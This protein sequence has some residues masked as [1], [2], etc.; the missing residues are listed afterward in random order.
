MNIRSSST[1]VKRGE[2]KKINVE[3][4]LGENEKIQKK[5]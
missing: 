3:S 2:Q 4:F 5:I 1:A